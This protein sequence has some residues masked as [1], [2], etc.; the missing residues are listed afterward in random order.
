MKK[1]SLQVIVPLFNEE[2]VIDFFFEEMISALSPLTSRYNVEILFVDDGSTDRTAKRIQ[3]LASKKLKVRLITLEVNVGHQAALATGILHATA[4][5]IVMMDG[6]LQHPP[7]L[8]L[9][10]LK[11]W[12][13]GAG[14]VQGIRKANV[15]GSFLKNLFSRAFYRVFNI[16]S[17]FQLL[18]GE[19]DFRL[20]DKKVYEGVKRVLVKSPNR[21]LMLR[22]LIKSFNCRSSYIEFVAPERV[23]GVSQFIPSKMFKLA[24]AGLFSYS[25]LPILILSGIATL[26]LT[27]L[28]SYA[29]YVLWVFLFTSNAIP[30]QTS[31][32]LLIVLTGFLQF[33]FTL[34]SLG[35]S[36]RIYQEQILP[37]RFA[38]SL[39]SMYDS[40]R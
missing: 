20:L 1:S 40:K 31:I 26:Y 35:Y 14:I 21:D 11:E 6:D 32:L 33:I 37:P 16:G 13:N 19:C 34:V 12:E 25:K 18:P 24:I 7:Q 38:Y 10:F 39:E 2:E 30:G 28:C 23:A 4:D 22:A 5:C 36:Y 15:N 9:D 3:K 8:I 27:L 17:N 29:M